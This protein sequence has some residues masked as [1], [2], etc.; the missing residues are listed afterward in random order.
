MES[1]TK[2]SVCEQTHIGPG[3]GARHGG[4]EEAVD[5]QHHEEHDAE[6]D[7]QVQQPHRVDAPLRAWQRRHYTL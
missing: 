1:G 7:G 2:L 6:R 4:A 3:A 5:E